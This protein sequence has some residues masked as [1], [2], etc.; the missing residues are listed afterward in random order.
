MPDPVNEEDIQ[1]VS[2]TAPND[3]KSYNNEES[4]RAKSIGCLIKQDDGEAAKKAQ[5]TSD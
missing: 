5:S 4:S 3:I 1:G 2:D